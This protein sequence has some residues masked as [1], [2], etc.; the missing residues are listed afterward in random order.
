MKRFYQNLIK[1]SD[2]DLAFSN[3]QKSM[4]NDKDRIYGIQDWG[5]FVLLH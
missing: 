1:E 5:G 4:R 3:A 2:I